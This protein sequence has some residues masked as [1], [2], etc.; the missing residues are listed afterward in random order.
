MSFARSILVASSVLVM[1]MYVLSF[2]SYP[3]KLRA[4]PA[5]RYGLCTTSN[6]SNY[7]L[8]L[9]D[10]PAGFVREQAGISDDNNVDDRCFGSYS[11][12]VRSFE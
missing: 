11:V 2:I 10:L 12:G 9:D 8:G 4:G 5:T 3:M 7:T 1:H 6:T